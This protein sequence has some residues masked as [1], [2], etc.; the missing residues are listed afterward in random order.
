VYLGNFSRT[1]KKWLRLVGI[2]SGIACAIIVVASSFVLGADDAGDVAAVLIGLPVAL[3]LVHFTYNIVRTGIS[4][5]Y[6]N[7]TLAYEL[8]FASSVAFGTMLGGTLGVMIASL[9]F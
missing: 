5:S 6:K 1:Q 9:L 2:E 3:L 8:I 4:K 7:E